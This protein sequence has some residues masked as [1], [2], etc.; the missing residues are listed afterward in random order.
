M[1]RAGPTL[2]GRQPSL[3]NDAIGPP[4][5]QLSRER[6]YFLG[7][8]YPLPFPPPSG[9]QESGRVSSLPEIPRK[10]SQHSHSSLGTQGPGEREE[11]LTHS[12]LPGSLLMFPG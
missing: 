3:H 4:A 6:I 12:L 9:P 5:S 2:L 10:K 11:I 7:V 8:T 1:T